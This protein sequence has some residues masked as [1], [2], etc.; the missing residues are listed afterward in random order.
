MQWTAAMK[1][2]IS[3]NYHVISLYNI[4]NLGGKFLSS[5]N[6]PGVFLKFLG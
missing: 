2:T 5:V 1:E 6:F 4:H 3:L